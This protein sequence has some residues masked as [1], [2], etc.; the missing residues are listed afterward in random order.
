[1]AAAHAPFSCS[2]ENLRRVGCLAEKHGVGINVHLAETLDEARTVGERYGATPVRF[3]DRLGLLGPRTLA[4]HCV[5]L[6]DD[7]IALLA[8]RGVSVAHN[9]QSNMKLGNGAAPVTKMLAAGVNV[10]LGTDGPCSN[11]DLDMWEELRTA[12]FLQKNAAADP[13]ALPAFETLKVATVNGAKAIGMEGWLG[14]IKEGAIADLVLLD[15]RKPHLIPCKNVAANLVYSGKASD[16]DTVIVAGR[17]VVENRRLLT[18]DVEEIMDK[19]AAMP[20]Q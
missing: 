19:V 17:I 3:V 20:M 2:E 15:L 13:I 18:F 8:E 5:H 9:P 10:G 1:M 7:E 16:V 14:I 11:N 12:S 6:S 4:N